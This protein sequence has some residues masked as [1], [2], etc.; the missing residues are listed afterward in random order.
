MTQAHIDEIERRSAAFAQIR[1][2][3]GELQARLNPLEAADGGVV[4]VIGELRQIRDRLFTRIKQIEEDEDGGLGERVKKFGETKRELEDRV[5]NLTEEF[6]RLAT[7]R[8]EIAGLFE[9]LSGAVNAS[10]N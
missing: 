1:N 5:A 4:S 9:K 7:I 10:A 2:R 6:S 8:R 3:L